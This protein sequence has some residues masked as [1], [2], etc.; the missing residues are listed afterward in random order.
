MGGKKPKKKTVQEKP[1]MLHKHK[2]VYKGK[3]VGKT[4]EDQS[5]G[6]HNGNEHQNRIT[7]KDV[8]KRK[9]GHLAF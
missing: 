3:V 8:Q 6:K 4:K 7:K 5:E 9:N 2:K 1:K